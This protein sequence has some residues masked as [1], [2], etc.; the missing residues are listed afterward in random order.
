MS[1]FSKTARRTVVAVLLAAAAST[2]ISVSV[3]AS[4]G[5]NR[6]VEVINNTGM[7]LEYL[8]AS[9]KGRNDWGHD[10][11]GSYVL[12]PGQSMAIDFN[13]YSGY[14]KFDLRA[15]FENGATSERYNV[16]VC[17]EYSVTFR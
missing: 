4:D 9:N 5:Y 6:V 10:H 7:A 14:C 3:S 13:D 8:H 12:H 17:S 15:T 16:N 1:N 2:A 11:L